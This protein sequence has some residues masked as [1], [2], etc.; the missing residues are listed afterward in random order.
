MQVVP[1][2]IVVKMTSQEESSLHRGFPE[3]INWVVGGRLVVY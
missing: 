2:L 1:E 3:M